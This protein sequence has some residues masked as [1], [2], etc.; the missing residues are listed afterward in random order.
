[1]NVVTIVERDQPDEEQNDPDF[2]QLRIHFLIKRKIELI[3]E[4]AEIDTKI[5][6]EL[7]KKN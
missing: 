4:I 7:S 6:Q 2:T 3:E 1:V 5:S